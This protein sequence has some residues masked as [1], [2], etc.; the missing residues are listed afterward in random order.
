MTIKRRLTV[1]VT[2]LT[3]LVFTLASVLTVVTLESRLISSIDQEVHQRIPPEIKGAAELGIP[4]NVLIEGFQRR[5]GGIERFLA[6]RD[7]AVIVVAS[8]EVLTLPA[9]TND[10]PKS[11]PDI[12]LAALSAQDPFTVASLDDAFEYR[13]AIH[14]FGGGHIIFA[15]SLEDTEAAV[16]SLSWVLLGVGLLAVASVATGTSLIINRGLHPIDQMI[17]TAEQ[18]GE[19]SL[20]QRITVDN[21]ETEVGHLGTSINAMLSRVEEAVAI[22]DASEAR[23]RRFAS[24]A[25]HELRTPL[26]SIL[27]YAELYRHGGDQPEEI[28]R[29]FGRI[30]SEGA[31]MSRML[32]QLLQLARLDQGVVVEKRDLD[33]RTLAKSLVTDAQVVEPMRPI[34]FSAPENPVMVNGNEDQV[35]QILTNLLANVRDHTEPTDP[36]AVAIEVDGLEAIVIV[37]DKGPGMSPED[38]AAAFERFYTSSPT[39]SGSGLGLSIVEAITSE[40]GGWV[41]LDGSDGTTVTVHLPLAN[42]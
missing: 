37:T 23:L 38:S 40:H 33:L 6:E 29:S 28:A 4:L 35:Q 26:T 2:L 9:G 15:V 21:A 22:R 5:A 12:D 3:F 7:I 31:R 11:L 25:S 42:Q 18:V 27:G 10:E 24:D 13:A 36:V 17:E 8:H 39:G 30:E 32:E 41:S 14:E 34:T 20:S 1:G 19:G 16:R